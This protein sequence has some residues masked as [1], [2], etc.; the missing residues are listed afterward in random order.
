MA[1]NV[2]AKG[3]GGIT[4]GGNLS[5]DQLGAQSPAAYSVGLFLVLLAIVVLVALSL[6]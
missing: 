4:L 5:L 3:T 6:R 1:V 2:Q